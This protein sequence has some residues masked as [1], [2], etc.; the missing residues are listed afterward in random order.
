MVQELYEVLADLEAKC[1]LFAY[2][3]LYFV[4]I[5]LI[6]VVIMFQRVSWEDSHRA[7]RVPA[8]TM[9]SCVLVGKKNLLP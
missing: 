4:C 5:F 7:T 6:F 9:F 3:L 2:F 8:T 1:G